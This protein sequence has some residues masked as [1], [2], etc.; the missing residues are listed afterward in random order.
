MAHLIPPMREHG[1]EPLYLRILFGNS[2][3]F[4][5]TENLFPFPT[6]ISKSGNGI[7]RS[8]YFPVNSRSRDREREFPDSRPSIVAYH[9]Y[10]EFFHST[11]V[12]GRKNDS[13]NRNSI[14]HVFFEEISWCKLPIFGEISELHELKT[15]YQ[16][17]S[18]IIFNG[19]V[20][21]SR[22]MTVKLGPNRTPLDYPF[23]RLIIPRV[24]KNLTVSGALSV[25]KIF[26]LSWYQLSQTRSQ[27]V[28]R[29][30]APRIVVSFP[31]TDISISSCL[32]DGIA[33]LFFLF[34]TFELVIDFISVLSVSS[35]LLFSIFSSLLFE[36]QFH[37][38]LRHVL[39][40]FISDQSVPQWFRL[41]FGFFA[42]PSF[43][44]KS[45]LVVV[46]SWVYLLFH[47][48]CS[49]KSCLH[50]TIPSNSGCRF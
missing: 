39:C 33:S 30:T 20:S 1:F 4:P 37:E 13:T 45:V 32:V 12:F 43:L 34:S 5:G 42:Q 35:Q 38:I 22:F 44:H 8:R 25:S 48:L 3:V 49:S 27:I 7:S 50:Q 23:L 9:G 2:R 24:L 11:D 29:C 47:I 14:K 40:I 41:W 31:S 17:S 28:L 15:A 6:G 19:H 16:F 10:K 21:F 36:Y 18:T 26:P 46:F